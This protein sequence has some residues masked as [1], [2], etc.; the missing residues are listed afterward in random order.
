MMTHVKTAFDK[1][2]ETV[3]KERSGEESVRSRAERISIE[4]EGDTPGVKSE[5]RVDE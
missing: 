5:K 2:S 4:G 1:V 3:K